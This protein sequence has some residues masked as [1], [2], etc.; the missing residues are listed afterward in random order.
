MRSL[1]VG[2]TNMSWGRTYPWSLNR[3]LTGDYVRRIMPE[4]LPAF[5]A[6]VDAGGVVV[7][8]GREQPERQPSRGGLPRHSPGLEKG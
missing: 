2:V 3:K 1:G 5:E 4:T 8:G 6:Y 7:V